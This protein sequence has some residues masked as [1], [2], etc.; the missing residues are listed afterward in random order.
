MG[1][2]LSLIAAVARNNV[3]GNGSA[4]PWALSS[5][6]KR[7]KHLT[8]GKPILMGRR[9][10]ETIGKPL[11]GRLNI[12]VSRQTDFA[13]PGVAIARTLEAAL[14]MAQDAV[15]HDGEIMI[16]GGG[17]IYRAT[18]ARA[19]RLYI[20]HVEASPVGDTYFPEIDP[21]HWRPATTERL[22]A[23]VRDSV[24]TSFVVYERITPDHAG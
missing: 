23:D 7:F 22:P 3:I 17:E 11:P 13:P 8:M 24:A 18:I 12:V 5:D 9:T 10:Y 16:I 15:E 1:I 4:L 2:R 6:L 14:V 20:T 19:A 21:A